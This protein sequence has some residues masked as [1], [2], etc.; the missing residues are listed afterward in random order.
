MTFFEQSWSGSSITHDTSGEATRTA[1]TTVAGVTLTI[2][3]TD[4]VGQF[5]GL[6]GG[7]VSSVTTPY[8]TNLVTT[9]TIAEATLSLSGGSVAYTSSGTAPTWTPSASESAL[10][11]AMALKGN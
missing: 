9:D 8:N 7:S 11:S 4:A 1:G 3:T 10:V 2:S 5:V 6:A